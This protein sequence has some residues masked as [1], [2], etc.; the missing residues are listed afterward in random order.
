VAI[1]ASHAEVIAR[2]E[3]GLLGETL[4]EVVHAT[5]PRRVFL[6]VVDLVERKLILDR[7]LL[8]DSPLAEFRL[9]SAVGV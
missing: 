5:D 3:R 6:H 1:C 8:L 2:I 7:R 4:H 9:L